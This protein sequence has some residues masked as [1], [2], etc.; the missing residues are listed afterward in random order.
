MK[1]S[2]VFF[3]F[4][5]IQA[6]FVYGQQSDLRVETDYRKQSAGADVEQT[7]RI[8]VGPNNN[9]L[10]IDHCYHYLP[11]NSNR[12]FVTSKYAKAE[13]NNGQLYDP[14]APPEKAVQGQGIYCAKTPVSTI[15][16]YGERAVRVEL[17]D[18]VVIQDNRNS[19]KIKYCRI[20]RGQMVSSDK[21]ENCK[22]KP[23]D[24]VLYSGRSLTAPGVHDWYVILNDNRKKTISAIKEWSANDD[25]LVRDLKT[26][27]DILTDKINVSQ[28][29]KADLAKHSGGRNLE[30]VIA[31]L[32]K[33]IERSE[34][35]GANIQKKAS[36][37]EI[38]TA[39]ANRIQRVYRPLGY[40]KR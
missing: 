23:V 8:F 5:L 26:A 28:E 30:T 25:L 10:L 34:N 27:L 6:G 37:T 35:D 19:K 11:E 32:K 31:D 22:S 33:V 13:E 7:N 12:K 21:D 14:L 18:D 1:K 38:A 29:E 36:S 15:V 9:P 4:T 17:A 16:T 40:T 39:K 24:M 2:L 3:C 20:G